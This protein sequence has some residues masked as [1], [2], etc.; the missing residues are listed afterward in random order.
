MTHE[1]NICNNSIFCLNIEN[2]DLCAKIKEL[3]DCYASTSSVTHISIRTRCQD[4]DIDAFIENVAMIKNKNEHIAKLE[5]KTVNSEL[6]YENCK[7]ARN[8]LFNGRLLGIKD[9]VGFQIGG[10]ETPKLMPME[11]NFQILLRAR[12]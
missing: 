3:N 2:V 12:L 11:R 6:E 5:A 7:F 1:L 9:D 4:I 8:M 10:K